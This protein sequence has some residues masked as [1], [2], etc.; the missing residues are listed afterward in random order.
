[1]IIKKALKKKFALL[2]SNKITIL[3]YIIQL[4]IKSVFHTIIRADIFEDLVILK[5]LLKRVYIMVKKSKK[6][7]KKIALIY[8]LK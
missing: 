7:E 8:K 5:R 3:D 1:M 6:S 4:F 2:I